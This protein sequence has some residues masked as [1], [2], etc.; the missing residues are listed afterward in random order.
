MKKSKVFKLLILCIMSMSVLTACNSSKADRFNLYKE[1]WASNNYP[2]MYDL[3]SNNS[4]KSISKEEFVEK[5]E[6]IYGVD[7]IEAKN[8]YITPSKIKGSKNEFVFNLEM[9]T[10]AGK[11]SINDY[12]AKVVKE[13]QDKKT[14]WFIEWNEGLIFPNMKKEDKVV[15]TAKS[16]KRGE[17]YD[18]KGAGL[19]INGTRYSLGIDPEQYDISSNA[20]LA[21]ILDIDEKNI[22]TKLK[23]STDKKQFVP[24]VNIATDNEELLGQVLQ[25]PGIK[26]QEVDARVYP[27]GEAFG[28]VIGAVVPISKEELDKDRES[29][30]H[31][32]SSIG[33]FGL[34]TVHEKNLRAEDGR[35]IYISKVKDGKEIKKE[36]IGK[37]EPKNGTNLYTTIDMKLQQK[38]YEEMGED[39]GA[40]SA[41]EPK[42]G[43][44]LA[45]VSSPSFDSNLY[46]TYIPN[47]QKATMTSVD[48]GK[49]IEPNIFLNRF[50][51]T[52][53][54]GST[55]K[56]VT[57]LIGLELDLIDPEEKIDIQGKS[58]RKD[59]TW[60]NYSVTRVNSD[61]TEV[62]LNDAL[63]Y[64]DNIYFA[65]KA[66]EI[67]KDNLLYASRK[68][69]FGKSLNAGYPMESSFIVG[70]GNLNKDILLADTGY[71]Q[72]EVLMS[73]LHMTMIYGLLVNDG[74]LMQPTLEIKQVK[75]GER[76]P[77][78]KKWT[79][80]MMSEKNRKILLDGLTNVIED[81]NGTGHSAKIEGI[82]LAG[83][84]GT[85]ELKKKKEDPA[86]ELGWFVAMNV[87]DPKIV[88]SMMIEDVEGRGGSQVTIPKVRNSIDYYLQDSK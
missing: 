60:G 88:I 6:N 4:K 52:Y 24:I 69:G 1:K 83:K 13:K 35:E 26:T 22:E 3:L 68:L 76:K 47:A 85:A 54:P 30:Y 42:T 87:D 32:G 53:S 79:E 74:D 81:P 86:I 49:V 34:E 63:V 38:I 29:V 12:K 27:G 21:S 46:T 25:I 44:I 2:A 41:M 48:T 9:D 50:N 66:L 75:E 65:K 19:A 33:R 62:N 71:G 7:G 51:K 23:E 55:F 57:S 37:K 39:V 28:T 70:L 73:P 58:W 80:N 16:G 20:Q 40:S 8:I 43:Q 59:G 64:S 5:Y 17:I 45:L 11:V 36:L 72:G 15:V 56:V 14:G 82:K 61:I 77:V 84:T 31:T 67:G 78:P 18:R 10:V